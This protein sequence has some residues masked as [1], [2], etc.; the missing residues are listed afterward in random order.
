MI[1]FKDICSKRIEVFIN[2][3]SQVRTDRVEVEMFDN[4]RWVVCDYKQHS[5]EELIDVI[6]R[7]LD[8]GVM[9]QQQKINRLNQKAIV[10]VKATI[11]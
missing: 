2:N 6:S 5:K 9:F 1:D 7:A 10:H 3:E 8:L 4:E 11:T